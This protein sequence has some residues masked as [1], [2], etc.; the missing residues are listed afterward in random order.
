MLHWWREKSSQFPE[1][2]LMARDYLAIPGTSTASERS[3]SN[4][5]RVILDARCRLG[6]ETIRACLCLKSWM[7]QTWWD[8]DDAASNPVKNL[9]L[10]LF[11]N[12]SQFAIAIAMRNPSKNYSSARSSGT[13]EYV[14]DPLTPEKVRLMPA[15]SKFSGYK[16]KRI[17]TLHLELS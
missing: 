10:K 4:G 16:N 14:Q 12:I 7:G 17:K 6:A 8:L 11:R 15:T 3:F 1:L 5:K 13:H 2:S 9:Y